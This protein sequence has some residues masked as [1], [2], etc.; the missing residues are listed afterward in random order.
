MAIYNYTARS[1][2]GEI[3]KNSIDGETED[4]VISKLKDM[5]IS[6]LTLLN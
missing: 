2:K 6:L 4:L 5:G 1:S 3:I